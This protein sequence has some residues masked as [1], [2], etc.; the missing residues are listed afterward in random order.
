[1]VETQTYEGMETSSK[2]MKDKAREFFIPHLLSVLLSMIVQRRRQKIERGKMIKIGLKWWYGGAER[3]AN[4]LKYRSKNVAWGEADVIGF[5]TNVKIFLL[6]LYVVQA[7]IYYKKTKDFDIFKVFLKMTAT[8]LGFKLVHMFLDVWRSMVGSMPSGAY[9]TSHGDSWIMGFMFFL[10]IA[11]VAHKYPEKRRTMMDCI[12]SGDLGITVYGDDHNIIIPDILTDIINMKDFH[13]YL[14]ETF[15]A[16]TRDVKQT[17]QFLSH[18]DR[19]GEIPDKGIVFLQRYFVHKDEI[20]GNYENLANIL[21]LRPFEKTYRKFAFG[22]GGYRANVDL[23]LSSIG[24]AYDNGLN[25]VAYKFCEFMFEEFRSI[26]P[27][28]EE[29]LKDPYFSLQDTS[30]TRLVKKL[31]IPLEQLAKGFPT[32]EMVLSMHVYNETFSDFEDRTPLIPSWM[33]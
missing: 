16:E 21:P 22:K 2:K 4:Q 13:D 15:D 29:I 7:A 31:G 19:Y 5:D 6:L 33:L 11:T 18:L 25:P 28:L 32:R 20:G 3:Y 26:C 10:Y 24:M 1:L 23:L 17:K 9:E 8:H 27:P 30:I 12:E 14:L